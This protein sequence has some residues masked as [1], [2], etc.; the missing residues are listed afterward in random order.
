MQQERIFGFGAAGALAFGSLA[1]ATQVGAG[2]LRHDPRLGPVW[3]V[4]AGE[5]MYPPWRLLDWW[6]HLSNLP[7][8]ALAKAGLIA[9]LG[10]LG[11][12]LA[13]VIAAGPKGGSGLPTTFGSARWASYRDIKAAGLFGA[14]GVFLGAFERPGL[15]FKRRHYLRHDGPEHV[16]CFAPTRS[17]KGIGLVLPTLLSWTGSAVIHDVKGENWRLS[18]GWRMQFSKVIRF[19]PTS[20]TSARYNPLLEIRKGACEVRDAQNVADMLVDPEGA[21]ERR[22]HWD[23]TSYALL[24][25]LILHILYAE[26]DKTLTR[27]ATL[28]ADPARSFERMLTMMMATNHLGSQARPQVHPVVAATARELLNKS[29]NE[30][31]GVLSTAVSFLSLYRDPLVARATEACDFR[32]ADLVAAACPVSLYLVVPPSDLS[33]TK[34]L[35]RLILNQIG[36]RLTE[37]LDFVGGQLKR[38]KL[39]LMLDE[40]PALGRLDFFETSLAFMAGYGIR[41]FLIAQS[42]NQ[43]ARHYGENSAIL[44]NCHIRVTFAANDERTARR[45]SQAL[46]TATEQRRVENFSGRR[47]LPWLTH[48]STSRH[49]T[50][51]PLLTAG[52]VMQLPP[53][54]AIVLASGLSPIRALK[55]RHYAD[56]N[57]AERLRPAPGPEAQISSGVDGG[58]W[59]GHCAEPHPQLQTQAFELESGPEGAGAAEFDLATIEP[60]ELV[61]P[62]LAESLI[63][64]TRQHDRQAA[65]I[66]DESYS[67]AL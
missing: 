48:M 6:L 2:A 37:E 19:D 30:R 18:A 58:D 27:A 44:D 7:Q 60:G 1:L 39:L 34:P 14:R 54:E 36:R 24:V 9:A 5:G 49:E 64:E 63:V 38:R 52:E 4:I 11:A 15:V 10:N 16:L 13:M 29:E 40:F 21:L 51:R 26:K 61:E 62:L 31:S 33:R 56:A 32:I 12:L 28:L 43:I 41:S 35:I 55:L 47:T 17:G 67:L 42:L 65:S 53:G 46:G 23:K 3:F 59:Q 45:I 20:P 50:A 8:L 57:F 22:N 66:G 25:G